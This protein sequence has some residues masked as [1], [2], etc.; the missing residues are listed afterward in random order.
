MKSRSTFFMT[1]CIVTASLI[2]IPNAMAKEDTIAAAYAQPDQ[3]LMVAVE[4]GKV[5]VRVNGI[6]S[7]KTIPAVFIHGGPGGT[8][9]SFAGIL[10]LA[11]ERPIILY[12][13]LDSGKSEQPNDPAN[14]RVERFVEELEAV[15][16]KLGAERW[17]LVGHS[18][19]SAIALEY[20]ARYPQH[21]A[22]TVIGGTYIS[23][24]HW[25]T[26]ANLLV[27]KAAKKVKLT[28]GACETKTPPPESECD[29][30]YTA[31]Y[32]QF[33]ETVAPS[34]EAVAYAAQIGGNGSNPVIYNAMWGPSEFTSTGSL[35][36]YDAVQLLQQIDGKQ[37]MFLVG[38]YDSARIDTVQDYVTLTPG[39]ELGVVPGAAHG[40]FRDRPIATEA[41]LRGW[42]KRNETPKEIGLE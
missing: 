9:N 38:Q 12:D 4:G 3:E 32:S 23:T 7:K 36:T 26:D 39:A 5:Y 40:F 11:D 31:L 1:L 10:S 21:V 33:Y 13:Q 20:T 30:A 6:I 15:R 42:F 41:I 34:K 2:L 24:P 37:T 27:Q 17:H 14:W 18:W 22:S 25:I 28:L 29:K 8:H 16:L 19:G 35:K